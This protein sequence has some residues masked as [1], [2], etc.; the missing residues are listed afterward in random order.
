MNNEVKITVTVAELDYI[1]NALSLCPFREVNGFIAKLV[2]Q[3]NSQ[4]AT[5]TSQVVDVP[6]PPEGSNAQIPS[7]TDALQKMVE[8]AVAAKLA[9]TGE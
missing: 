1:M 6:E 5:T 7:A 8:D 4:N 3:A 9:K 2:N